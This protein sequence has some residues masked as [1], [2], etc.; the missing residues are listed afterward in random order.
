[1]GMTKGHG[2]AA[3]VIGVLELIIGIALVIISFV[4]ASYGNIKATNSPW[5]LGF[6][7]RMIR[8]LSHCKM[9]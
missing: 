3:I 9:I 1:M 6:A 7:V 2:K 5:W 8:L 4:V